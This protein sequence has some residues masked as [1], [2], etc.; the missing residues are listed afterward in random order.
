MRGYFLY[1]LNKKIIKNL[2]NAFK[3]TI[4]YNINIIKGIDIYGKFNFD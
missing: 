4:L 3:L 2:T 1:F